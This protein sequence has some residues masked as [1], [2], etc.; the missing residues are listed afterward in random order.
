M[1]AIKKEHILLDQTYNTAEEA[2]IA[3]GEFLV[4][5]GLVS[6]PYIQSMLA[7]HRKVSVYVGNF[8]A[9]PH[10]DSEGQVHIEE[11]GICLIQVPDGVNFGND[12]DPQIATVLFVVALKERQ[13]EALQDI[14]FFCSDIENVMAL[15]DAKDLQ[16]IQDILQNS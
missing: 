10:G 12:L 7:R 15:S 14:A 16:A 1:I 5:Q 11:E 9:L 2:I 8:V 4:A 6:P 3:A 13:L